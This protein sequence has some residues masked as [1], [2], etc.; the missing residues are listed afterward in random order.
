MIVLTVTLEVDGHAKMIQV[1]SLTPGD[2]VT[3]PAHIL[4]AYFEPITEILMDAHRQLTDETSLA[5]MDRA[6]ERQS[7]SRRLAKL[8]MV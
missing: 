8:G 5:A 6:D 1:D 3:G 7:I 4:Q 2:F